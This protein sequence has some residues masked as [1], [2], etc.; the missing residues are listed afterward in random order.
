VNEAGRPGGAVPVLG[1]V[2]GLAGGKSTVAGL[3]AE[4][5]A[6]VVDADRIGHRVLEAPEVSRALAEAFGPDVLTEAGRVSRERLAERV[7]GRP[8]LVERLN[9]IVHPPIIREVQAQVEELRRAGEVPLIALDAA[10]LVETGLDRQMCDALLFVDAPEDVR[11]RRAQECRGISGEQFAKRQQAQLPAEAKRKMAH[12]V[13]TNTG[14]MRD[15]EEQVEK[16]WPV[17]CRIG[18]HR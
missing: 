15:L 6:A 14:R 10:L 17:L 7:F 12:Y 5:G 1:I 8:D 18:A 2:G 16:L 13:V 4:R 11:R 9:G 3:L